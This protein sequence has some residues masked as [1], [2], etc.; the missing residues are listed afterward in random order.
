MILQKRLQIA[1]A[2]LLMVFI[3]GVAGYRIMGLSWVDA[4]YMTLITLTTVGYG[5]MTAG[6][7]PGLPPWGRVFTMFLLVSG[8]G[9]LLYGISTATAFIVEGELSDILKRRKMEKKI[10]ELSGHTIVCGIGNLGRYIIDELVK[11]NRPFVVIDNDQEIIDHHRELTT[12]F[13]YVL[14]DASEDTVLR[15][16]GIETA[17]GIVTAFGDDKMNLFVTLT[18]RNLNP[19]ARIVARAVVPQSVQKLTRSGADAAVSTNLI[20]GLRMISE[21]VRPTVTGFL[22]IMLRE[23][24]KVI[25]FEEV[26]IG[27]GSELGG[28]TIGRANIQER[29]GLAVVAVRHGDRDDYTY[30]PKGDFKLNIGDTLI[31]LGDVANLPTLGK[32][33]ASPQTFD[34]HGSP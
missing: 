16:A 11:T 26:I 7:E 18:A 19:K 27:G 8:M 29:T 1:V 20:G 10:A 6:D 30:S 34:A 14:G 15:Q 25:R 4:A 12:E 17:S 9:V 21:L 32:I 23:K 28:Q 5:E 3:V 24:S 33:C 13:L 31:I 2:I 22:D